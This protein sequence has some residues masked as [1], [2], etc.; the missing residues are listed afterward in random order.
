M[1]RRPYELWSNMDRLFDQFRSNFDDLFWG[2][3]TSFLTS[4]EFRT[5]LMDIM[6]LGDK[7]EMHVE[8][9]GIKKEDINIEVTPTMVE[10]SAEHKET[11]E[12]KGKNWLR[13]ERSSTDFYRCLELPEEL[14]TGNV[15]A[16]LKDG[17]L[18]LSLPKAEPKPKFE[19]KKVKIK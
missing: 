15:D 10:I 14:K 11:S 13:Q 17:V 7:Y 2:P 3:E 5:P 16:E 12:K 19:T 1:A 9:P 6:D 4:S 8:M 18:R